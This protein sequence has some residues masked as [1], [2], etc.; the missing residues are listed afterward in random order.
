MKITKI[1]CTKTDGQWHVVII[2]GNMARMNQR[3]NT[4]TK[5]MDSIGSILEGYEEC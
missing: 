4:L 2:F 5:A 3:H 1:T